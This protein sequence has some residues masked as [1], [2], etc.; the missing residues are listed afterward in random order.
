[1]DFLFSISGY[2]NDH[3]QFQVT[4]RKQDPYQLGPRITW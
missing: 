1:M 2:A 4:F 3:G